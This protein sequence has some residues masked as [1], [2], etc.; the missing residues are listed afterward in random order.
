MKVLLVN[1]SPHK[2]GNTFI[3]LSEAAKMLNELGIET[4][5]VHIGQKP[6]R[7]C[8]ACNKCKENMDGRCVFNDDICNEIS[9]KYA[10]ADGFIFGSPVY[11]GQPN[12]ALLSLMQRSF[13]SNGAAAAYKPAACVA[14]CR[15]GG[16]TA[17]FQ[18]MNIMLQMCNMPLVTSQY[19][20]IAYGRA[21]GEAGAR[22]P[23]GDDG[24]RR[25]GWRP[26]RGL[27]DRA[28]GLVVLCREGPQ[29]EI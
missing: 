29:G 5:I 28:L 17:A 25:Q 12:G 21:Q 3:A 4:E 6:M 20:N 14:V 1:G 27:H 13:Y 10:E 19:W 9:A 11:F 7:G 23:A 15:R 24:P 16:A 2:Q 26:A 8:I 18:T 22:R